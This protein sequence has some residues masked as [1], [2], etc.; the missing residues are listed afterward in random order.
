ML[1]RIVCAAHVTGHTTEAR[2]ACV[3]RVR[4]AEPPSGAVSARARFLSTMLPRS[5]KIILGFMCGRGVYGG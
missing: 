3:M 2:H 5:Q 1:R 4:E